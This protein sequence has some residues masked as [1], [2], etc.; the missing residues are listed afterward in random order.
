MGGGGG[1]WGK[2]SM[3]DP[4]LSILVAFIF[5]FTCILHLQVKSIKHCMTSVH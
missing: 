1:A 2:V 3:I 4:I 5:P